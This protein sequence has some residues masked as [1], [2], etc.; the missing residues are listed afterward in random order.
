MYFK[1]LEGLKSVGV[2][3]SQVA[4][5]AGAIISGTLVGVVLARK[6]SVFF[7]ILYPVTAAGGIWSAFYLSSRPNREQAKKKMQT[8]WSDIQQRIK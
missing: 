2:S 7:R 6:K 1:F 5:Q 4:L 8:L 3:D